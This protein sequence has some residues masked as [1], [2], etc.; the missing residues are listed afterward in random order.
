MNKI[1][2]KYGNWGLNSRRRFI[3]NRF[4]R[5]NKNPQHHSENTMTTSIEAFARNTY[6]YIYNKQITS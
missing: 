4:Y 6:H 2:T 5:Q 3:R 1:L